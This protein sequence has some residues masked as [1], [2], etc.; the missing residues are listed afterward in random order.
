MIDYWFYITFSSHS[1]SY[2]ILAVGHYCCRISFISMFNL[3][4]A[5][6]EKKF[7]MSF[8]RDWKDHSDRVKEEVMFTTF[9]SRPKL[10]L[11]KNFRLKN[12]I[13]LVIFFHF[14]FSQTGLNSESGVPIW[15]N[16]SISGFE[17]S[18]VIISHQC[19]LMFERF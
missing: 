1:V 13:I 7:N 5:E 14:D 10:S 12:C 4:I 2:F 6:I 17:I 18:F 8:C 19:S 9:V 16:R 15:W 11:H 3:D